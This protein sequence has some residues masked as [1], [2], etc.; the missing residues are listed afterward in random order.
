[1]SFEEQHPHTLT[2]LEDYENAPVGTIVASDGHQAWTKTGPDKWQSLGAVARD[3][4]MA[5]GIDKVL[6]LGW[7]Q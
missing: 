4:D 5:C 2:T 1:M 6:R 7:G 3:D